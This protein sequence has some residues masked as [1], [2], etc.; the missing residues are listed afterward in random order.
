[1]SSV[2]FGRQVIEKEMAALER[3]M[4]GLGASFDRAV[5]LSAMTQFPKDRFSFYSTW[6]K[7]HGG[8]TPEKIKGMTEGLGWLSRLFSTSTTL[9]RTRM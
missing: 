3:M 8:Y 1:M 5:E 7:K 2:E 6:K 9:R 4:Q